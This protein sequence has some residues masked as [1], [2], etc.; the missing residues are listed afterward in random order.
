[1]AEIKGEVDILAIY[2]KVDEMSRYNR[3]VVRDGERKASERITHDKEKFKVI[4]CDYTIDANRKIE[5]II[6]DILK[7]V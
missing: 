5:A 2:L 7:I 3:L 4:E 6:E 1:M